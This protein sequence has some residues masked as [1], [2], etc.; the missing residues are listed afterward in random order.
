M[1][2][3]IVASFVV[4]AGCD[5]PRFHQDRPGGTDYEPYSYSNRTEPS[6]PSITRNQVAQARRDCNNGNTAACDWIRH[7]NNNIDQNEPY[8][9]SIPRD[10]AV[11]ARRDC[12]S[13]N[14]AACTWIRHNNNAID[15]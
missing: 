9:T 3:L 1:R 7:N 8:P 10:K 13:G 2:A 15:D 11:Q 6:P 12:D 4:L 5:D 14:T